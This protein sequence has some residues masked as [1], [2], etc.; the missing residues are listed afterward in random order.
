MANRNECFSDFSKQKTAK[1][2]WHSLVSRMGDREEYLETP[3]PLPQSLCGRTDEGLSLVRWRLKGSLKYLVA[4]LYGCCPRAIS[5]PVSQNI[6]RFQSQVTVFLLRCNTT[7]KTFGLHFYWFLLYGY[8]TWVVP[9][10]FKLQC[11][12]WKCYQCTDVRTMAACQWGNL[13]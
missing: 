4:K 1:K 12:A 6:F 11:F 2:R 7:T 3:F 13:E 5:L 8:N 10:F 9:L